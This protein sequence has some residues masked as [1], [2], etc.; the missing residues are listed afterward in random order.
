MTTELTEP[1]A[2]IVSYS[3]GMNSFAEAYYCCQEFGKENVLLLFADTLTED[4]DLYRFIA[5]TVAFLGCRYVRI[6]KELSVW[7]LFKQHKFIGNSRLDLCS[8]VLKR[9]LLNKY[10][11]PANFPDYTTYHVH[12]GIDY[13][14]KHRL[15]AIVQHMRPKT[16]RSLLIEKQIIVSK[17]FSTQFDIRPPYLY[18]LGMAHNNCGGFCVKAGL[19][20]F[21]LLFEKLPDRYL[22]HEQQE[23]E[24]IALG[25]KPFLKKQVNGKRD[26][27]TMKQYREQYL[28]K[29]L[30]DN[31]AFDIGGCACAL[32]IYED[33]NSKE[34]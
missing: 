29:G 24:V 15:A 6:S 1:I 7:D 17:N 26:F 3:G 22:Y 10:W 8:R 32:P 13:I 2:H 28:E 33:N 12:V 27:I 4:P 9:D 16:Y 19:G 21:K 23:Q 34:E 25:A 31:D 14:E 20:Q 11:I 18:S 30:A 5:D